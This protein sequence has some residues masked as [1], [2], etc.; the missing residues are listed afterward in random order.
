MSYRKK[1]RNPIIS[2]EEGIGNSEH[3]I[4]SVRIGRTYL[5]KRR[6]QAI[7]RQDSYQ[8]LSTLIQTHIGN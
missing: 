6:L 1:Q 7:Q 2:H 8:S 5:P 3:K 4:F